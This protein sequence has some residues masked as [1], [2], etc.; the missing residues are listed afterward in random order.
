MLSIE[1]ILPEVQRC[2]PLTAWWDFKAAAEVEIK[3]KVMN[4]EQQTVQHSAT[5]ESQTSRKTLSGKEYL[6]KFLQMAS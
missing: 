6:F 3:D 1:C 2:R 5:G 4:A